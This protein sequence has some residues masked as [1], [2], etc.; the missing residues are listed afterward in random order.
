MLSPSMPARRIAYAV[1]PSVQ[2]VQKWLDDLQ[3]KSGRTLEQWVALVERSVAKDAARRVAFLKEQHGLDSN[4]TGWIAERSL[5]ARGAF[6]TPQEYL[7]SAP[8]WVD[9]QFAGKKAALRPIGD[10]LL[11]AGQALGKDVKICPCQTMVP[12]FR[13]HV[14]AQ[15]KASTNTRVDLGLALAK[16]ARK[17]P[18]R[19]VDTGGL[20]K[21]DRITHRFEIQSLEQ[22]DA[23]VEQ[24]L[25]IAYE[26]DAKT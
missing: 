9:Q 22:I 19:L 14:F 16:C 1:H 20:A 11:R 24:W 6:D 13:A 23:E 4:V 15:V 25:A 8:G 26:L 10:A 12:L 18:K 2:M 21:K 3:S 5:G 17:L 7:A